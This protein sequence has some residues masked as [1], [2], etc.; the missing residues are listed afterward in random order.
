LVSKNFREIIAGGDERNTFFN[1]FL[2]KVGVIEERCF[3]VVWYVD[4]NW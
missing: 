2:R 1:L 3:P 4:N